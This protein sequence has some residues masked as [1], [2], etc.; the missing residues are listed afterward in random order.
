M[1]LY[2]CKFVLFYYYVF[3]CLRVFILGVWALEEPET[4][5]LR[6]DRA[7]VLKSK[8]KHAAISVQLSRPYKFGAKPFVL[9]Y[10]V[11]LQRGQECGGAYLKVSPGGCFAPAWQAK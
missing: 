2:F 5:L 4:P 1:V 9:Q 6:G 3:E 7:L 10:E 11:T 8:A